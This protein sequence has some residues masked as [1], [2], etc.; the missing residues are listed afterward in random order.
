M[1]R[2][3]CDANELVEYVFVWQKRRAAISKYMYNI[4]ASFILIA[5]E[6]VY[7]YRTKPTPSN[8]ALVALNKFRCTCQNVYR[9][10]FQASRK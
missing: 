3:C 2:I 6:C 7:G 10:C 9:K 8:A 4:Y 1:A 5:S